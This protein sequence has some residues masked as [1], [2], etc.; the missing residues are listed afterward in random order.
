[1]LKQVKT[2]KNEAIEKYVKHILSAN[3]EN[4]AVVALLAEHHVDLSSAIIVLCRT[5]NLEIDEAQ[6]LLARYPQWAVQVK[7]SI[8]LTDAFFRTLSTDTM[9]DDVERLAFAEGR[10]V[11]SVTHKQ[12][13]DHL[14]NRMKE[15]GL[16]PYSGNGF[17]LSY[18]VGDQEFCNLVGRIRGSSPGPKSAPILLGA[19]YD[20]CGRQPGADDNA[21]ACAVILEVVEMLAQAQPEQDVIIA[22][23]DAE[24]PPYF[25]KESMGSTRFYNDQMTDQVKCAVIL[26]LVGHDTAISKHENLY[27]VTGME[28]AAGLGALT[29]L[30]IAS[31][32]ELLPVPNSGLPTNMSDYHVFQEN[33]RPYLFIT[34][35]R[36]EHYHKSTDTADRLNFEKMKGLAEYL[37]GTIHKLGNLVLGN[38]LQDGEILTGP[39]ATALRGYFPELVSK[40]EYAPLDLFSVLGIL[41][42]LKSR[43]KL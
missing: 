31:E 29:Q 1:M 11:G 12:A 41:D 3:L 25:Q 30:P 19:H 17:E 13:R 23:F 40:M 32:I 15:L 34:S 5:K 10:V 38:K 22:F 8:Q 2:D 42:E 37:A 18:K 33:G 39:T 16:L 35:G 6:T 26:D 43:F 21:A 14:I 28:S 9:Q 36:W 27:L 24:E 4:E 7:Q 20:T